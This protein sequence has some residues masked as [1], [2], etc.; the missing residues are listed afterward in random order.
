MGDK[1]TERGVEGRVLGY[2]DR[3]VAQGDVATQTKAA[4]SPAKQ[5]PPPPL[6]VA[7]VL[8][9]DRRGLVGDGVR[10]TIA[11]RFERDLNLLAPVKGKSDYLRTTLKLKFEVTWLSK[12]PTKAE[13]G[14][15][16]RL[17]FPLYFENAHTS[18]NVSKGDIA[19][20]MRDHGI[21]EVGR[22]GQLYGEAEKGWESTSVEG[23]GIP[24]LQGYRKVG[25][26]KTDHIMKHAK[27]MET[28]YV[29]VVK[30]EF[31]H[32]C[33]ITKHSDKGLMMS[34]V[35]LL[36]PNID[37]ADD[38]K[39]TIARQLQRL[40]IGSEQILQRAYEQGNR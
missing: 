12:S 40:T 1:V 18:D 25:F 3:V 33:S 32:M 38:D 8:L 7:R 5:A 21:R 15:F 4:P 28:G 14:A 9:I 22:A 10:K 2:G 17:D 13:R 35:P 34:S 24:P 29:N 20:I 16:G 37:Y 27:D 30:H 23:L 31:G 6:E 19:D 36:T 11:A 39:D 26:I